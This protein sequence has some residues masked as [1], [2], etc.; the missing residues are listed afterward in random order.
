MSK[1]RNFLAIFI[2]FSCFLFPALV[3]GYPTTITGE[4]SGTFNGDSFYGIVSGDI[5]TDT[6]YLNGSVV[7]STVPTNFH[8]AAWSLSSFLSGICCN[9][10]GACP[11][12]Q[13][14]YEITDWNY[15][16]SRTLYYEAGGSTQMTYEVR[17]LG[18][19][20]VQLNSTW[21]GTYTG[22]TDI[23]EISPWS[24]TMIPN[25]PGSVLFDGIGQTITSGGDAY[26]I[27]WSGEYSFNQ[28]FGTIPHIQESHV[29]HDISWDGTTYNVEG[30][31][32]V[33]VVPEPLSVATLSLGFMALIG[34]KKRKI[35]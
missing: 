30:Y 19:G 18:G 6:G 17:N 14:I 31:S 23:V 13:P 28:S 3:F 10:I 20:S 35:I 32:Y 29:D 4:T 33:C 1:Q 2:V 8:P 15:D 5:E 25:G 7:F 26:N 21:N 12:T 9:G 34:I 11:E 22:P 27:S 16:I 24:Q